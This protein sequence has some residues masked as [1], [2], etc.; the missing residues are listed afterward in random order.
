MGQDETAID[1][2]MSQ[3]RATGGTQPTPYLKLM[4]IHRRRN[5]E[6]SYE[7][8]RERLQQRFNVRAPAWSDESQPPT[9]ALADY[10]GVLE[11]VTRLWPRPIDAMARIEAW[12]FQRG[13]ENARFD[14]PAYEELV[15]LYWLARERQQAEGGPQ[16][17][18]DL[19]LP[20][21]GTP[22]SR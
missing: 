13:D 14:L 3:L 1:L 6:A 7:R 8:I 5:D 22:P 10:P 17:D 15:M 11:E 16:P 19:L 12:M 20:I 9:R 18:I 4:Q 21:G 2:L